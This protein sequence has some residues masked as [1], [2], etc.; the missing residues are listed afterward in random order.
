MKQ[1]HD[2]I[3]ALLRQSFDGPAPDAGFSDRVMRQLP[4]RRRRSA[5]PLVTGVLVGALLCALSLLDSPLWHAAWQGG[6]AGEWSASTL[7][8]LSI[9]AAMSLLAL[10]W[11]LAEADDH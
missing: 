9:M 1:L 11:S 5:W 6:R 2:D 3:D 4:P 7:L 8:I 10:A